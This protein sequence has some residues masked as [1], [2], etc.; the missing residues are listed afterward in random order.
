MVAGRRLPGLPLHQRG[1]RHRL[2]PAARHLPAAG[3]RAGAVRAHHRCVE[4][5]LPPQRSG[6]Q[7]VHRPAVAVATPAHNGHLNAQ[8]ERVA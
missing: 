5:L 8:Y 1:E 3:R 7:V 6:A 2:H 4:A